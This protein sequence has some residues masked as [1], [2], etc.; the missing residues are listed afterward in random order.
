MK[1]TIALI[2]IN[3]AGL[4]LVLGF[5]FSVL[6]LWKGLNQVDEGAKETTLFFKLLL[7]PGMCVFWIFFVRKWWIQSRNKEM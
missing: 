4:Y 2:L 1:E 7:V 5:A 6:F 3:I